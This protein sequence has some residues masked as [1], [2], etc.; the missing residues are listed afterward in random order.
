MIREKMCVTGMEIPFSDF[1]KRI[2][3]YWFY[4]SIFFWNPWCL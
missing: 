4:E 2:N 1:W 3:E